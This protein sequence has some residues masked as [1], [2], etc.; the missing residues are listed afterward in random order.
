MMGVVSTERL[1]LRWVGVGDFAALCEMWTDELVGQFMGDYGPRD[2]E[3]VRAW[4]TGFVDDGTHVQFS[5]TRR[6]DGEVV[7]WLGMGESKEP[8][9]DWSFGYA[10]R[11]AHR[12]QGYMTEALTAGLEYCRGE[13][14]VGSL[15]GECFVGNVASARVMTGAGMVEI[16]PVERSRRFRIPASA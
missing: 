11:A 12:G 13:L 7:G 15:W 10:V 3:A 5:V 8:V 9:A 2:E 4:L 16:E 14:G 1:A 6:S